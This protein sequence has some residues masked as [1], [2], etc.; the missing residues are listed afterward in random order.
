MILHQ[1]RRQSK[2]IAGSDRTVCPDLH[3]QLVV[4][5]DLP[6]TRWFDGVV[7]L[8]HRRVHGIDGNESDTQ[9]VFEIPVRGNVTASA[10]QAHFHFELAALAYCRN[11]DVLIEH[12]HIAVGLDRAARNHARLIG[13]QVNRLWT[14]SSKFERNLFQVEDDVGGVFDDAWYRLELMQHAF[15]LHR[16]NGRA[17][18]RTQHHAP[19]RVADGGAESALKWL[20]PEHP[21]FVS[22]RTGITRQPFWF[23]KTSPKHYVFLLSAMW[24]GP[25]R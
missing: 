18:D 15:D 14:I 19:Q 22:K 24:L 12:F 5:G 17:F 7:A 20:R 9:I 10:L 1:F 3:R 8:A 21:V 11:V 16:G 2:G 23:L 4:I 6:Q 13:A 25:A